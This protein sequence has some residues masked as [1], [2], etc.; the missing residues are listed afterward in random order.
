MR[1]RGRLLAIAGLAMTA[2]IAFALIR[3]TR[4]PSDSPPRAPT[5]SLYD[6]I[7]TDLGDY[8][9]PT[10][11][12]RTITSSFGE[13]RSTHFHA[14]IDISTRDRVGA[15]V[16]AARDG[17]V[18]RIRVSPTGYG[19]ILYV[20]H[21]DGY[22]TT[23]AHLD[24]FSPALE[25]RIRAEQLRRGT[26]PVTL[27]FRPGQIPVAR[28]ELIAFSGETGSGTPHLHFEIRDEHGNGVNPMLCPDF[29]I[30]DTIP[31]GPRRFAFVPLGPG[32][33]VNGR[34][35]PTIVPLREQPSGQYAFSG[36]VLISGRAG[37]ALYIR[38]RSNGTWFRHGVYRHTLLINGRP[39][40]RVIFDRVPMEEDQQI[41]LY[42]N[43]EMVQRRRGR[44][45]KLYI[46]GAHELPLYVPDSVG[47][48]ILSTTLIPGG[49][50]DIRIETEDFNGNA[51]TIS[52]VV[53]VSAPPRSEVRPER[54]SLRIELSPPAE[55]RWILLSSLSPGSKRWR[56]Q[57][58][59]PSGGNSSLV[60]PLP[61]AG[62]NILRIVAENAI[63]LQSAPW[64]QFAYPP[65]TGQASLELRLEQKDGFIT[66][67]LTSSG[68][69]TG[70]PRLSIQEGTH[71][72]VVSLTRVDL[73]RAEGW[74]VPHAGHG[75]TRVVR[76]EAEVGGTPRE[77]SAL[78]ELYP[79]VPG[80]ADTYLVDGGRLRISSVPESVYD[81]VW[82]NLE[83]DQTPQGGRSYRLG[84]SHVVLKRGITVAMERDATTSGDLYVRRRGDWSLLARALQNEV[85]VAGR[86]R[87]SLG[88][89]TLMAD[90]R[91]PSIGKLDFPV[92]SR[93]QIRFS[94]A[95]D[96]DL[97]G[98]D[99]DSLKT[100]IDGAVVIPEIDG[101]HHR[102][103]Y[104]SRDPLERGPHRLTIRLR[105]NVGNLTTVERRFVVP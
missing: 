3:S 85:P 64:F 39:C 97:A 74:F 84:P 44:F 100:Y 32:S 12:T 90:T 68:I 8:R 20:R 16:L 61:P 51:T 75:G 104:L 41:G 105:D 80:R 60:L 33:T 63:G 38:D 98:V 17:H 59:V 62:E 87:R 40:L 43:W 36:P 55:V 31:P 48:G 30:L 91:G 26:Y 2:V 77:T 58:R 76:A 7:R 19:K 96:D 86:L 65:R 50:A 23:Y 37:I 102:V 10:D 4:P 93:R 15:R 53:V 54:D 47:T 11:E 95:Y 18:V 88:E 9:W 13:F 67:V 45:Q 27:R 5:P 66:A 22:T 101:E 6:S 99:Y 34:S 25:K 14:G 57:R 73:D 28:G 71:Q 1:G 46:D 21:Q 78:L 35:E 29:R 42:Y 82:V 24:R 52:G 94:F 56:L 92:L 69:F 89:L 79:L 72:H 81:T 49:R 70:T 103:R 83:R